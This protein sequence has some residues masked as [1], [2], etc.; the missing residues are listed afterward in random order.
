MRNEKQEIISACFLIFALFIAMT[1]I[2]ADCAEAYQ[3][4]TLEEALKFWRQGRGVILDVRTQ[5]EYDEGHIPTAI[6]VPYDQLYTLYEPC[7]PKI[8]KVPDEKLPKDNTTPILVYCKAGYRSTLAARTLE[9]LGYTDISNMVDG[10]D[11]W[12][13]AG[14]DRTTTKTGGENEMVAWTDIMAWIERL[15]IVA[16]LVSGLWLGTKV[17]IHKD[18]IEEIAGAVLI[19]ICANVFWI[20]VILWLVLRTGIP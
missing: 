5:E 3:N 19:F 12:K 17:A 11:K 15:A 4:V 6:L 8:V 14:Y 1:I 18:E 20:A 16:V 2:R 9:E 7:K 10:F 13:E